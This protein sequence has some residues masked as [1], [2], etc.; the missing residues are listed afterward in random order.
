M[1]PLT[2]HNYGQSLG[3]KCVV[4]LCTCVPSV[5]RTTHRK[6]T[7]NLKAADTYQHTV[8]C[9]CDASL[10][11]NNLPRSGNTPYLSLPTTPRPDTANVLAES[12]SVRINVQSSEFLVPASL[13][14]SNFGTPVNTST[15]LQHNNYLF[16]ASVAN[17]S[18]L[19]ETLT[20]ISGRVQSQFYVTC[21]W[22][23][24]FLTDWVQQLTSQCGQMKGLNMPTAVLSPSKIMHLSC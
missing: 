4:Y 21:L 23:G 5:K 9:L 18:T 24:S 11:F 22:A 8:T 3:S 20:S 17:T 1:S 6:T 19:N 10:T 12:P 15:K 16:M 7:V 13:A 14:S 2:C